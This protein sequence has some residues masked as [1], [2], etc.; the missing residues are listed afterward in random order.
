MFNAA[1]RNLHCVLGSLASFNLQDTSVHTS[2][3]LALMT[4]GQ[5]ELPQVL[6]I[7]RGDVITCNRLRQVVCRPDC[8]NNVTCVC[9]C[10]ER[11]VLLLNNDLQ[12]VNRWP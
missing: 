9:R 8:L 7:Y 5:C 4:H 12:L 6:G 2:V 3:R 11:E 1:A 10:R